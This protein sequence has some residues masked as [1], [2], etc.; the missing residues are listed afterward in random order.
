MPSTSP[1]HPL[2]GH[3]GEVLRLGELDAPLLRPF[4]D[5]RRQGV[6]AAPLEARRQTQQ[7]LL[8]GIFPGRLDR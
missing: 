6:L 1:G 7:V 5:R 2:T 8:A 3:R 4:D